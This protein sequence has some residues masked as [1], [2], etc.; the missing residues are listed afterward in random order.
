MALAHAQRGK[1]WV[2]SCSTGFELATTNYNDLQWPLIASRLCESPVSLL[3]F[4]VPIFVFCSVPASFGQAAQTSLEY[5]KSR[6]E[7]FEWDHQIELSTRRSTTEIS[8]RPS[9][10]QR[11]SLEIGEQLHL[12]DA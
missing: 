3:F 12:G 7:S 8:L 5:P 4:L 6:P 10:S 2:T 11:K 1:R 9:D